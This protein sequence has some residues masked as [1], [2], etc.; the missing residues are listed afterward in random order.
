MFLEQ[1]LIT[2]KMHPQF[3][4]LYSSGSS[5][6]IHWVFSSNW[7]GREREREVERERERLSHSASKVVGQP[8]TC[9]LVLTVSKIGLFLKSAIPKANIVLGYKAHSIAVLKS[10]STRCL[11][12]S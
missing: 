8:D 11:P 4:K 5:T 12:G 3:K 7:E 9:V 10:F 1:M 6:L 2:E